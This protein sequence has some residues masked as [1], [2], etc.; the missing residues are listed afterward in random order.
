MPSFVFF[1]FKSGHEST[2]GEFIS[3]RG[4]QTFIILLTDIVPNIHRL[5][6]LSGLIREGSL[7]KA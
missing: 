7:V 5:M 2:V 6:P 4:E 3:S 1:F